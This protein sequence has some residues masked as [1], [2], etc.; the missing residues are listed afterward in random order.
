MEKNSEEKIYPASLTKIMT[1]IVAIE[2]LPDLQEQIKLPQSMFQELYQANATMAGFQPDEQVRAMD[3]L[4]GV[5]L[6]SGAESCI[7]LAERIAGSERKFALMMNQKAA[8]LGMNH[9][10][11]ENTTGLHAKTTTQPS[12]IWRFFSIMLC[13]MILSGKFSPHPVI[14]LNLPISILA[15]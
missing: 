12:R 2:N 4:Y 7:G 15:E 13:R 1:A 9:T 14:L 8:E 3:L 6:P 10:N 11:F 5:M